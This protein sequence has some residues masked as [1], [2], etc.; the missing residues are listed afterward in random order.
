MVLLAISTP[1]LI[2]KLGSEAYGIFTFSSLILAQFVIIELGFSWAN[3]KY[4]SEYGVKGGDGRLQKIVSSGLFFYSLIGVIGSS[5]L[6]FSRHWLFRNFLKVSTIPIST[7]DFVFTLIAIAFIGSIFTVWF[8]SILQGLQRLDV[9]G[10]VNISF[11]TLQ[12][13]GFAIIV[14]LGWGLTGL[15]AWKVLLIYAFSIVYFFKVRQLLPFIDFYPR[16]HLETMKKFLSFGYVVVI[17]SI[18]SL[19]AHHYDRLIISHRFPISYLTFYSIPASLAQSLLII[20]STLCMTLFPRL[21]ELY[22]INRTE[23][24]KFLYEKSL[25]LLLVV[26]APAVLFSGFFSHKLLNFYAGGE[27]AFRGTVVFKLILLGVFLNSLSHIPYTAFI[28]IGQVRLGA[29]M[30]FIIGLTNG[31]AATILARLYGINGVAAAWLFSIAIGA[32]Y[33]EWRIKKVLGYNIL[34]FLKSY[35]RI[36]LHCV[37]CIPVLFFL[38]RF[39]RNIFLLAAIFILFNIVS[40]AVQYLFVL[41]YGE[42]AYLKNII[43]N[44][45]L[46][47]QRQ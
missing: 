19:F 1:L 2:N 45:I 9:Y 14:L 13:S 33:C 11:S 47:M 4:I 40:L 42:K 22:S 25:K 27:I 15:I 29:K 28:S 8:F 31:I 5:I 38:D 16:P 18:F 23:E 43:K 44:Y 39:L 32:V 41:S 34:D 35:E 46:K 24:L 7:V 30:T 37:L 6:F 36:F 12:F 17:I 10:R 26:M 21:S 20:P 3:A